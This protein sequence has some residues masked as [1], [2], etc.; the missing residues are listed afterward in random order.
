MTGTINIGLTAYHAVG[1]LV[2]VKV[3][4]E[5]G[6]YMLTDLCVIAVP[7]PLCG[8]V[9]GEPCRSY[10]GLRYWEK[11][12]PDTKPSAHTQGVHVNRKHAADDKYGRGWKK[13]VLAH[14]RLH[15]AASDVEAAMAHLPE[16]EPEPDPMDIDVP[17]TRRTE[18]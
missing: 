13:T 16:P 17:V 7:C 2:F 10:Y 5:R 18:G 11:R 8:A 14:Y 9:V 1:N 15:L 3:P 12:Y 4:S 6:R